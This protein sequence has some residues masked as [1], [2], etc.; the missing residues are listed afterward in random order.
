[1][2][3]IVVLSWVTLFSLIFLSRIRK[4]MDVN[5]YERIFNI[6]LI[7]CVL[8]IVYNCLTIKYAHLDIHSSKGT[9]LLLLVCI[10]QSH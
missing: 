9:A 5:E 3:V 6:T 10:S 4:D 7:T 1:M 8:Y 2:E